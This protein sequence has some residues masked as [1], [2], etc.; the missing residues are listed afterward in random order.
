MY[1]VVSFP[2]KN[3]RK[4]APG[5]DIQWSVSTGDNVVHKRME[6]FGKLG[7]RK[8]YAPLELRH[9]TF[10]G[11]AMFFVMDPDGLPIEIHE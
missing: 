6:L 9:D 5:R 8:G 2:I 1:H 7:I 4:I 3:R 11:D 10:T